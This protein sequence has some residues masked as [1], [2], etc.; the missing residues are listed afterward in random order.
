[1]LLLLVATFYFSSYMRALGLVKTQNSQAA[2]ETEAVWND[3]KSVL[4]GIRTKIAGPESATQ[5]IINESENVRK[6]FTNFSKITEQ[7][8][9]RTSIV[10]EDHRYELARENFRRYL[11]D[12]PRNMSLPKEFEKFLELSTSRTSM[13]FKAVRDYHAQMSDQVGH[14]KNFDEHRSA[15]LIRI[16]AGIESLEQSLTRFRDAIDTPE[17]RWHRW[18]DRVIPIG[19]FAVAFLASITVAIHGPILPMVPQAS[20]PAAHIQ[21]PPG[22]QSPPLPEMTPV[23]PAE[24]QPGSPSAAGGGPGGPSQ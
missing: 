24:L 7:T 2:Q 12:P 23:A 18:H 21:S 22:T 19:L 3:L 4:K 1:M 10:A 13:Y 14:L 16:E 8:L 5:Q 11:K 15:Q 20:E 17:K 6:V 9:N